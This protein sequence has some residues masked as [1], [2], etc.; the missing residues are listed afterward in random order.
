MQG[1]FCLG[2]A[3]SFLRVSSV[4]GVMRRVVVNVHAAIELDAA[5][6]V[7]RVSAAHPGP[8]GQRSRASAQENRGQRQV[9]ASLTHTLVLS[10]LRSRACLR[11]P[12]PLQ[13]PQQ[14]ARQYEGEQ[15]RPAWAGCGNGNL[16]L[17]AAFLT[18]S[19]GKRSAPGGARCSALHRIPAVGTHVSLASRENGNSAEKSR[20]L[21]RL[22]F[23][24]AVPGAL[25][26]PG[27]RHSNLDAR[28]RPEA[29][30]I[31]FPPMSVRTL[32]PAPG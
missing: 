19:P 4:V 3:V 28:F 1:R 24:P 18:R 29:D 31:P 14:Y 23:V 5:S 10:D 26:L 7:A 20:A 21:A 12:A 22:L 9:T 15:P 16:S 17:A 13:P 32:R 8:H 2:E 25:R 6:D 30:T 27:L 11:R